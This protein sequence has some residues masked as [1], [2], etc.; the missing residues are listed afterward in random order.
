[1]SAEGGKYL[2]VKILKGDDSGILGECSK[3]R[4]FDSLERMVIWE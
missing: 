3:A 4:V 1:L 2:K